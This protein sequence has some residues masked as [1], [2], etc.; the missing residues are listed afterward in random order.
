MRNGRTARMHANG[1]VYYLL[2]KE[3][4]LPKFV[5]DNPIEETLP[6]KFVLPILTWS[7]R[8]QFSHFYYK[9]FTHPNVNIQIKS[10]TKRSN[11]PDDENS[12]K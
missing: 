2:D 10:F 3:D 11:F 1:T 7:N 8:N 9:K 4:F 6:K 12:K 5:T